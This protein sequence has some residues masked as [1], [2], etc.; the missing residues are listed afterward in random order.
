MNP[1]ETNQPVRDIDPKNNNGDD[2]IKTDITDINISD[3]PIPIYLSNFSNIFNITNPQG[4]QILLDHS[5]CGKEIKSHKISSG[6]L[7][8]LPSSSSGAELV[9][10]YIF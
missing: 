8:P 6:Q 5:L 4:F 2:T 9:I 1:E 7:L 10:L 3:I